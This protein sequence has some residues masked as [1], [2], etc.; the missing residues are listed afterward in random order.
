[1]FTEENYLSDALFESCERSIYLGNNHIDIQDIA[2]KDKEYSWVAVNHVL[3]H[4]ENDTLALRELFRVLTI[5]GF[6]QISIP[7]TGHTHTTIDWGYADQSKMGH[8]RNYGADFV[9]KLRETLPQAVVLCIFATD[10]ISPFQDVIYLIGKSRS[11]SESIMKL[12]FKE[13]Y[14]VVP[15]P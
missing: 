6:I 12:L 9:Y 4:V 11:H 7:T 2:R 3:E 15:L 13:Q 14:V 1:M 5:D 8:F 10:K